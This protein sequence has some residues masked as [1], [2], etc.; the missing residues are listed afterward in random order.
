M[1]ERFLLKFSQSPT[2]QKDSSVRWWYKAKDY[3]FYAWCRGVYPNIIELL[4]DQLEFHIQIIRYRIAD[5]KILPKQS[6]VIPCP[7]SASSP[8]QRT[9]WHGPGRMPWALRTRHAGLSWSAETVRIKRPSSIILTR[10]ADVE[11]TYAKLGAHMLR[12]PSSWDHSLPPFLSLGRL[13]GPH[14]AVKLMAIGNGWPTMPFLTSPT[15]RSGRRLRIV[16]T[17]CRP[18]A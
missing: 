10:F 6:G 4:P 11:T 15:I 2:I 8:G 16:T 7:L 14:S 17:K 3:S 9:A 18:P 5:S 13:L 1:A 12:D